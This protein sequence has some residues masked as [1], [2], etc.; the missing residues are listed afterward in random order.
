VWAFSSWCDNDGGVCVDVVDDVE[1]R[2]A[3]VAG[4]YHVWRVGFQNAVNQVS[5]GAFAFGAGYA[6]GLSAK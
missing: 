1:K 5:S 2:Y 4:H 6:Y 3:H